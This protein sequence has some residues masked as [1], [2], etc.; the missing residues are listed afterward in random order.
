MASRLIVP[1]DNDP[2]S[3]SVKTGSY[4]VPAG[5]YDKVYALSGLTI[6]GDQ[7]TSSEVYTVSAGNI[8]TT[9]GFP[10]GAFGCYLSYSMTKSTT[11]GSKIIYSYLPLS[12]GATDQTLFRAEQ[13]TLFTTTA[14]GTQT[15]TL[16]IPAGL[17]VY[18]TSSS[19][20]GG[21]NSGSF[22]FSYL[23]NNS[24]WVP[25]GTVLNG[26]KYL[27]EEYNEIS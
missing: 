7:V 12:S 19:G 8:Y 27:V 20:L 11:S 6:N 16:F 3:V 18:A 25:S 9:P 21:T 2:A 24:Y 15:G 17:W 26:F 4:T 10:S 23:D 13:R 14:S 22:T 1:F 5:K